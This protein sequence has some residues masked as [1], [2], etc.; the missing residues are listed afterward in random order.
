MHAKRLKKIR[1]KVVLILVTICLCLITSGCWDRRELQERNFVLAVGIDY[2]DQSDE[3]KNKKI[4]ETFVQPHGKKKYQLNLQVLNLSPGGSSGGD[5]EGGGAKTSGKAYV[6]SNTGHS[7]FEMIRDMSGQVGRSLWFEHIHTIVIN[8]KLLKEDG[9]M[10]IIDFLSRDTEMRARIRVFSTPGEVKKILEY[11]PPSGEPSGLYLNSLMRNHVKNGHLMGT[12][13]DM[14]YLMQ[15]ITNKSDFLMPRV[16]LADDIL[17]VGGGSAIKKDKMVGIV[18][19]YTTKGIKI[20]RATIKSAI[21]T[22]E[23]PEHPGNVFAFEL[24]QHQ[25]KLTPHVK[26]DKI[27]F[28]FETYMIG[29]IGELQRSP[30]RHKASDLDY[31]RELEVEFAKEVEANVRHTWKTTHAMKVDVLHAG[32][33]LKQKYPE[34]WEKVK[35]DWDDIL[36]TIPLADVSV[37]ITIRGTGERT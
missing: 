7:L 13:T 10:P 27:Y 17:K 3:P 18:D 9:I 32:K 5:E 22:I 20:V 21:I 30:G 36:P 29:N 23:C 15:F 33:Q 25:S 11:K 12:R 8:E 24:F 28:T 31:V 2:A 19:E 34:T 37:N 4:T 26:G 6:I 16:E 1:T 35:D 14:G